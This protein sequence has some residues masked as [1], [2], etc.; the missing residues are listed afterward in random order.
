MQISRYDF[1]GFGIVVERGDLSF[2]AYVPE[3]PGCVALAATYDDVCRL[4]S[5]AI[6]VHCLQLERSGDRSVITM[7]GDD[8]L[9]LTP[10]VWE[11]LC[12]QAGWTIAP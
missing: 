6:S 10:G 12:G 7:G 5:Q 3:L 1:G 9:V 2:G 4:L 11:S 8:R